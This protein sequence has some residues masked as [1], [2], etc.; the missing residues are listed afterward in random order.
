M[1]HL[2]KGSHGTLAESNC[3]REIMGKLQALSTGDSSVA[4]QCLKND[5]ST[6]NTLGSVH[7]NTSE[8]SQL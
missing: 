6:W 7:A 1:Q 3:S 4:L 8:L 5:H 2:L